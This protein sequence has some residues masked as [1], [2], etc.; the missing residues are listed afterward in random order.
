MNKK[1]YIISAVILV[2][3][4]AVYFVFLRPKKPQYTLAEVKRGNVTQEISETGTVQKG[5][6]FNL[7][8]KNAGKIQKIYVK[9]G[10]Q[11]KANALLADLDSSQ[12]YYQLQEARGNLA[13]Y[14][15]QLDKLLAGASPQEIQAAQTKVQNAEI[16][17]ENAEQ[18]LE[19]SYQDALNVVD[20]A[21]LKSYNAQNTAGAVQRTYFTGADQTSLN[22]FTG[23]GAIENAVSQ[24]KS[25]LDLA[26][27]NP[28]HQNI[29][30]SI[31][32]TK[33]NLSII[34]NA[35]QTI[36]EG[37]EEPNYRNIV[38]STDKT[39]LDT[40][41]T[42]IN[43]SLTSVTTG[44]QA[45]TASQ[46]SV[47]SYQGKLQVAKDSQT[48]LTAAPRKEDVDLHQAQVSQAQAQVQLL[49]SQIADTRLKSPVD[50]Q[51]IKIN[52][53][54][55][56]NVQ[57]AVDS[58]LI[59]LLPS[60]PF[61]IKVDIYEE[62][63]VKMNIGNP[64]DITLVAFPDKTFMGKVV[65]IDPGQKLI[66]DVVYYETTI[67]F[68]ETPEN[69]KPGMSA[70][71]TIKTASKGNVLFIPSDAIQKKDSKDFVQV[72]KNNQTEDREIQIGLQGSDGNTEIISGLTEGEQVVLK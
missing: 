53:K 58:D 10:D 21:Y 1:I 29:D 18:G 63:V 39:S 60:T 71:L 33:T 5:E 41:R 52:K 24:I 17:L 46:L 50:G 51:I 3:L 47:D 8:F 30:N 7:T 40:H 6:N 68:D 56:E 42:N 67:N 4:A 48:L 54:V 62:D 15:S 57:P 28:S 70:D 25:S 32:Q 31:T 35:L 61:E 26:K 43:T 12:M 14:Q 16:D 13:L 36:R 22:V 19:S 37:C 34:S 23:K 59:V 45:I 38:S 66:G 72:F 27:A 69:L 55:G 2:I 44:Q 49:E 11:V 64:V 20:D 65:F 9:V